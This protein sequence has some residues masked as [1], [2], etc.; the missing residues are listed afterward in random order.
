M[1]R[2]RFDINRIITTHTHILS[3]RL[4][5]SELQAANSS[6]HHI[7]QPQVEQ[8]LSHSDLRLLV[9]TIH[10]MQEIDQLQVFE[11]IKQDTSKYTENRNGVFINLSHL[12]SSTLQKL[13][14][15][16]QYWNIQRKAIAKTE[17]HSKSLAAQ[18]NSNQEK[19]M[20]DASNENKACA[21][22]K[23]TNSVSTAIIADIEREL[24]SKKKMDLVAQS[25]T[26]AER[27]MVKVNMENRR[28]SLHKGKKHRFEGS[29]ARV[30]RKCLHSED[31]S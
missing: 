31:K 29:A 24:Q 20:E 3:Y 22:P 1:N 12:E 2:I 7:E 13:S 10:T 8:S 4:M 6:D 21:N 11:I 25:L 26:E 17:E 23:D 5:S 30:A 16:V 15:F 19:I 14:T 9:D 27:N 28:I 18:F